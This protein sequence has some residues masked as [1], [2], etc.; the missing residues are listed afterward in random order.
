MLESSI[1]NFYF[2]V[3]RCVTKVTKGAKLFLGCR[4]AVFTPLLGFWKGGIFVGAE[5]D[6]RDKTIV[7]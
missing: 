5:S 1:I 7:D 4:F 6:K 2:F 3:S